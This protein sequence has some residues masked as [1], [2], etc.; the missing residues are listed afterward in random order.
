VSASFLS[1][2]V[3]IVA[4][5]LVVK[6]TAGK[7][8]PERCNQAFTVASTAVASGVEV[9]LWLAGEAAWFALPGQA[10]DFSLPYSAP[11]PDLIGSVLA[12]GAVS[13]CSQC[14]ARRNIRPED[15]IP[16]VRI[17][18]AATFLSEVLNDDAKALVY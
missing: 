5:K 14:A 2:R 12:L 18:G 9:S 8:D 11:L 1:A 10:D 3:M 4:H 7:E 13:V 16:G 17:A 15:V 6:V